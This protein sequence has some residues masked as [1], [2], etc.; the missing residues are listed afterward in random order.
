MSSISL[1]FT[2]TENKYIYIYIHICKSIYLFLTYVNIFVYVDIYSFVTYIYICISFCK[3][4][5]M[6]LRRG[7]VSDARAHS[8]LLR[9]DLAFKDLIS[10]HHLPVALEDGGMELQAWPMI[11]P[12]SM[13]GSLFCYFQC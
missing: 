1:C 13:V 8:K 9:A 10:Y 7:T 2:C 11:L 3:Y 6:A 4:T 12:E 5:C